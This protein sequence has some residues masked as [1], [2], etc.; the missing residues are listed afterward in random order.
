MD[1]RLLSRSLEETVAIGRILGERLVAGDVVV[2]EGELAAGKTALA[3]GIALGLGI[4]EPVTS[5]TFTLISEYDG[6]LHLY[7]M[8]AYRLD[9]AEDFAAL[10][11]E[12]LLLGDGV[13]VVEWGG[14][15]AEIM[16]EGAFFVKIEADS[17]GRREILLLNWD[18]GGFEGKS[19]PE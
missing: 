14:K 13:S 2:L 4:E 1:I 19:N 17:E 10:G 12:D 6:R 18:R 11:A 15:I 8:D 7:H 9:S 16:P 5:P 3:K